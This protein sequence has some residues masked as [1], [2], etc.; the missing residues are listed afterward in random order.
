VSEEIVGED[1]QV[2]ELIEDDDDLDD[3]D[4]DYAD[5]DGGSAAGAETGEGRGWYVDGLGFVPEAEFQS[6]F[7]GQEEKIWIRP[8]TSSTML[9]S[10][11]GDRS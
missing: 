5:D 8:K 3:A 2:Y 9:R 7:H 11:W 1:G 4:Y 6:Y 10:R